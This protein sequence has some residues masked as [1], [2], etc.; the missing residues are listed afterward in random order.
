LRKLADTRVSEYEKE[1]FKLAEQALAEQMG[2]IAAQ[3]NEARAQ[4]E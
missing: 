3:T 2:R 1:K 4:L